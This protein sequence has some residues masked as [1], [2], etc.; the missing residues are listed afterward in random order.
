V[1]I[2][3]DIGKS[4]QLVQRLR[5][6]SPDIAHK[7]DFHFVFV[8]EPPG[9]YTDHGLNKRSYSDLVA[10]ASGSFAQ[11]SCEDVISKGFQLVFASAGKF[12]GRTIPYPVNMLRNV[13]LRYITTP[14]VMTLDG[15][16]VP[17][18]QLSIEYMRA[19]KDL[20][21]KGH[22]MGSVVL[23]APGVSPRAVAV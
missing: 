7:V 12:A 16:L 2:L 10:D 14:H 5:E 18:P 9:L 1:L 22:T 17:G 20:E 6:C 21:S 3:N 13:A 15:D 8:T 19:M 23:V 11:F 4:H